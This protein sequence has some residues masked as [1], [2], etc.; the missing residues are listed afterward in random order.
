MVSKN[1]LLMRPCQLANSSSGVGMLAT[2]GGVGVELLEI[3]EVEK[4]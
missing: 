1:S 4:E 3:R 2:S